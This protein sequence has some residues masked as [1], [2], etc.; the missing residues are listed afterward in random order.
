[1]ARW[2]GFLVVFLSVY[3]LLHLYMLIKVRR[4]LYLDGL[5]FILMIVVL[6]FLMF[7]PIQARIMTAHG[8]PT[9]G[10]VMTW[11]G[12]VWMGY[13]FIFICIAAPLDLYHLFLGGLQQLFKTDWTGIMLMRRHN[14]AL[15][16]FVAAG[17]MVYGAFSAYRV[18]TERVTLYTA[19]IPAHV[20]RVRIVQISDL[21]LGTMIYP[22]RLTP[23]LDAIRRA[24][25]DILVS[26]GDLIDGDLSSIS[27][28]VQLVKALPAPLGK[29]AVTGNHEYYHGLKDSLALTEKAG[30]QVLRNTGI[31]VQELV[32]IAGVDDPAAGPD[33]EAE[34]N[35]L[36]GLPPDK[37]TILL[38]HR[39]QVDPASLGKFDLQLSGHTHRGQIFPFNFVVRFA[40]P[41]LDGLYEIA[42]A[43]YLYASRGTGTW[44]PPVRLL[45]PPE[46]T[47]ID[48]FPVTRPVPKS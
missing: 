4:A 39:P 14:L 15:T 2:I 16:S 32:A 38:K 10:P 8:Y 33:P 21:H 24:Q 7:A 37:F 19:K 13:I 30:F 43:R 6:A 36:V 48:L 18:G 17:L 44:G 5:S 45:A 20:E 11:I 23:I 26:T 31:V 9:L 25:P 42:P 1:M 22:G 35:A 47:I 28:D 46:I 12:Y 27:D 40:Y 3:G 41:L 29:F 34:A